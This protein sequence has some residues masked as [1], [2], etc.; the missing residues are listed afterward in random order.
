[1]SFRLISTTPAYTARRLHGD[2][3][4]WKEADAALRCM[5]TASAQ[6]HPTTKKEI[7]LAFYREPNERGMRTTAASS[8]ASTLLCF[9]I[10]DLC[11]G[12]PTP[13]PAS[14]A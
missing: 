4:A 13:T 2:V 10:M 7:N 6:L 14:E 12:N 9:W 1:N 8:F 5:A 3:V 11:S